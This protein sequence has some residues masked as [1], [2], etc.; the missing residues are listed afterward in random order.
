MKM[1][2]PE[3]YNLIRKSLYETKNEYRFGQAVFN[4]LP[5]EI[6]DQIRGTDKDFFYWDN[7]R[8]REIIDYCYD[9]LTEV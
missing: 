4:N 1:T 6:A 5:K 7:N 9:E 8:Q 2:V 3:T